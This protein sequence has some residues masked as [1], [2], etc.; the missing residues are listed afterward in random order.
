MQKCLLNRHKLSHKYYVQC[1][2]C[3]RQYRHNDVYKRNMKSVHGL[4]KQLFPYKH[5]SN[6]YPS[7][8][9]LFIHVVHNH[10]LS[11]QQQQQ[12]S[13]AEATAASPLPPHLPTQ[14]TSVTNRPEKRET[15][16]SML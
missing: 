6:V 12:P 2:G 7:Y 11:G 14:S 13:A 4:D 3:K 10:P 8:N 5:F 16:V 1:S 15:S 9:E